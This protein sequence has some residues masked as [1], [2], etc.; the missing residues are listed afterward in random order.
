MI[1]QTYST[2]HLICPPTSDTADV[3]GGRFGDNRTIVLTRK[4]ENIVLPIFFGAAEWAEKEGWGAGLI[5]ILHLAYPP[6]QKWEPRSAGE[7]LTELCKNFVWGFWESN[8]D[9]SGKR[10]FLRGIARFM[11]VEFS[12]FDYYNWIKVIDLVIGDLE[13]NP[14]WSTEER[15]EQLWKSI[16]LPTLVPDLFKANFGNDAE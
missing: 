2:I 12:D 5:T 6:V 13:K 7:A 1:G 9:N 15:W 8:P 3:Q 10:R 11:S 14:D 4:Q 16:F